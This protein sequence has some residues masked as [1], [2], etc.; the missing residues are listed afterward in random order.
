[1]SVSVTVSASLVR[2]LHES[3]AKRINNSSNNNNIGSHNRN[4]KEMQTIKLTPVQ[5][6]LQTQQQHQQRQNSQREG[7]DSSCRRRSTRQTEAAPTTATATPL[8]ALFLL[9]VCCLTVV[10][11][12]ASSR[13]ALSLSLSDTHFLAIHVYTVYSLHEYVRQIELSRLSN[14]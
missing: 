11:L 3:S 7:S 2:A 9:S 1:M 10:C 4:K 5:V 14:L 13:L 8:S 6:P 12:L